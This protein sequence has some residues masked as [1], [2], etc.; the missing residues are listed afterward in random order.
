MFSGN[1]QIE[2]GQVTVHH[3]ILADVQQDG[4][5]ARVIEHLRNEFGHD[6]AQTVVNHDLRL[7]S[8]Q[9]TPRNDSQHGR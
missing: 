1:I 7:P 9:P 6:G 2:D 5:T 8:C 4:F 3:G